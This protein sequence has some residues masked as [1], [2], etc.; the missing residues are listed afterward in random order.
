M[1]SGICMC[2]AA[3]FALTLLATIFC[4]S[5]VLIKVILCYYALLTH[6]F[7][8]KG[9]FHSNVSPIQIAYCKCNAMAVRCFTPCIIVYTGWALDSKEL[10]RPHPGYVAGQRLVHACP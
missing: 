7:P 2:I 1:Y 5:C 10:C 9:L 3:A 4:A 6:S 8:C